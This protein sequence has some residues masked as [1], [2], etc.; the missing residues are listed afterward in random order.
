MTFFSVN[1]SAS[2]VPLCLC[3]S[4]VLPGHAIY[5]RDAAGNY[6]A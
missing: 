1:S 6:I 3:G 5:F 4:A 2:S